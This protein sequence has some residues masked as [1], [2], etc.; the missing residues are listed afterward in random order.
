MARVVNRLACVLT[1]VT[2]TPTEVRAQSAGPGD[3]L[4]RAR[5]AYD[6]GAQAF[7]ERRFEDAAH[8]FEEAARLSPS[9]VAL[10]T[11]AIAWERL[12]RAARAADDYA[13]AATVGGLDEK[14]SARTKQ[15]LA[16]LDAQ[17][18]T[19]H[20]VG[21]AGTQVKLDEDGPIVLVPATLH[22]SAGAHVLTVMLPPGSAAS[23]PNAA[24]RRDVVLSAGQTAD[25]D[26]TPRAPSALPPR[27]AAPQVTEP[28]TRAVSPSRW[29]RTVRP[30]GYG[31]VGAG[32]GV[33]IGAGVLWGVALAAKSDF[34]RSRTQGDKDRAL[35]LQNWTNVALIG[36]GVLLG[37]G[38]ACIFWP[39][40][41]D[42]SVST[43]RPVLW[44]GL[45][46]ASVRLGGKW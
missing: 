37:G 5:R 12:G 45:G 31:L 3:A 46:P 36:G 40:D 2:S 13:A 7:S 26:A 44:V 17:V 33:E 41:R 19:V 32:A 15:R 16:A 8:A 21:P 38:A 43:G 24:E 6:A 42:R 20:V 27:Y 9:A 11:A 39:S 28:S 14:E 25:L 22:G 4:E 29:E 23:A 10:F 35:A 30:V 1:I 34:L 18:G